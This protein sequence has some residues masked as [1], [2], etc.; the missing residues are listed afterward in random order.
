MMKEYAGKDLLVSDEQWQRILDIGIE[1]WQSS[2]FWCNYNSGKRYENM[3]LYAYAGYSNKFHL[4]SVMV[5]DA[6]MLKHASL[7]VIY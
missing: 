3:A 2:F 6:V 1:V 5:I 7:R 4:V